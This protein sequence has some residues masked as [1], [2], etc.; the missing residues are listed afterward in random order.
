MYYRSKLDFWVVGFWIG[1]SSTLIT[2]IINGNSVAIILGIIVAATG[3]WF[4][5]TT[6]YALGEHSLTIKTGPFRKILTYSDIK[7][8]RKSRTFQSAPAIAIDRLEIV[9]GDD[10][11]HVLISPVHQNDFLL[12]LKKRCHQMTIE[13]VFN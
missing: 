13:G 5:L 1:T 9:Y 2:G 8:I 7:R 12:Q 3:C 10:M 4:I 11:K 6:G